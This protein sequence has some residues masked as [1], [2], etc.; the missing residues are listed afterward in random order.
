MWFITGRRI[1][2]S[3]RYA[4]PLVVQQFSALYKHETIV[5]RATRMSGKV[6]FGLGKVAVFAAVDTFPG[7]L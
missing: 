1:S 3:A 5:S 4:I 7:T 2:A 6:L